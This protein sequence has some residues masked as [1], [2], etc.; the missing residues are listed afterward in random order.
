MKFFLNWVLFFKCGVK[1]SLPIFRLGA[2]NSRAFEVK[3][4]RFMVVFVEENNGLGC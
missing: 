2:R 1:R 4:V 3:L